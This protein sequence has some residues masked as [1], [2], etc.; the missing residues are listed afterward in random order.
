MLHAAINMNVY[1]K[2]KIFSWE[3]EL[4]KAICFCLSNESVILWVLSSGANTHVA[5][6]RVTR[7]A[8][9]ENTG[10]CVPMDLSSFYFT[11]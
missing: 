10:Q 4:L 9:L 11:F 5:G 2:T 7:A 6:G 8:R 1:K 3:G